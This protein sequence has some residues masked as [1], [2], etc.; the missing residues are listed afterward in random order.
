MHAQQSTFCIFSP[1]HTGAPG[2]FTSTSVESKS[3]SVVW[4]TVPCPHVHQR[5][6]ITG[7]RL[8]YSN[9]TSIVNTTGEWNRQYVLTGLTPF[10]NYSYYK[11]QQSMMEVLDHT[12]HHS[13]WRYC[14]MV[15][16]QNVK[17]LVMIKTIYFKI[18]CTV[19]GPVSGLTATLGVVQLTRVLP[20]VSSQ[21]HIM[22]PHSIH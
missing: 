22:Q 10:T 6:P 2:G 11:W 3:L 9:G 4:G 20:M 5:G 14:R 1:A 19:P 16:T 17:F 7:C 18:T 8:R 12:V 13:L 21:Q 15:S